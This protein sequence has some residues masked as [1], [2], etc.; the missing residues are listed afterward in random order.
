MSHIYTTTGTP[1]FMQQ[2]KEKFNTDNMH[3]LYG[4]SGTLLLHETE[5]K[6]KFQTPRSYEVIASHGQFSEKGYFYFYHIPVSDD[7]RKIFEHEAVKLIQ[8][9]SNEPGLFA[10]RVLKPI[11]A[12]TYLILSQWSGASSYEQWLKHNPVQ[13]EQLSSKQ[14]I[15]TSNSYTHVYRTKSKEEAE[16]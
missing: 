1:E 15:F 12:D 5:G 3:V 11:K 14:N 6:T 7:G 16:E 10:L 13:L 4:S 8:T 2:M 9:A